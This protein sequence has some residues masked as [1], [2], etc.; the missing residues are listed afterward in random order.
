MLLLLFSFARACV[1]V[2]YKWRYASLLLLLCADWIPSSLY[3]R[4]KSFLLLGSFLI[5]R[6]HERDK[7]VEIYTT[8]FELFFFFSLLSAAHG[9]HLRAESRENLLYYFVGFYLWL[10]EFEMRHRAQQ[11]REKE[12]SFFLNV[13][14]NMSLWCVLP[15]GVFIPRRAK[16]RTE[17]R[18]ET[19]VS[20]S[21]NSNDRT[22]S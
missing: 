10:L 20:S 2:V 15:N 21:V 16:R 12:D 6:C 19:T 5:P 3:H 22:S 7:R 4:S 1:C 17:R 11:R 9:A 18:R 14:N 13:C 8:P